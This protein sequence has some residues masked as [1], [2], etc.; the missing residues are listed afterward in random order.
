M[1]ASSAMLLVRWAFFIIF[2]FSRAKSQCGSISEIFDI[3]LNQLRNVRITIIKANVGLKRVKNVH[4]RSFK[5][6]FATILNRK[7]CGSIVDI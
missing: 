1:P 4:L 5:I 2:Q 7:K 3:W 6:D